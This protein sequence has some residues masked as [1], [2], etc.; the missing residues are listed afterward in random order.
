MTTP[1]AA[2]PTTAVAPTI[3]PARRAHIARTAQDFE[4]SFLSSMFQ[5]MF[6]G[7]DQQAPFGGGEAETTWRSFLTDAMA[8]QVVR[9]GGIGLSAAVARE[10]LRMQAGG[11]DPS[12]SASTSAVPSAPV[13][14]PA[15]QSTQDVRA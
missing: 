8:R 4:S 1:I 7:V 2:P 9:T 11:A 14:P 15:T 13:V 5:S 12:T 3:D 10:M 6:Q